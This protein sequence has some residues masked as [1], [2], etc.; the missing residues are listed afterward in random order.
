MEANRLG[1]QNTPFSKVVIKINGVKITGATLSAPSLRATLAKHPTHLGPETV[2][3]GEGWG[4]QTLCGFAVR[5]DRSFPSPMYSV[6]LEHVTCEDCNSYQSAGLLF[7]T[8]D[9]GWKR[10]REGKC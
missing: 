5:L 1:K 10:I 4:I 3:Y 9:D 7:S 8:L 6:F 2:H